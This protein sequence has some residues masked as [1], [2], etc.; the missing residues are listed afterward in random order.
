MTQEEEIAYL[1]AE[2]QD[3]R[4]QLQAALARIAELE[5]KAKEPPSFVKANAAKAKEKKVR[6]K[7]K[8]E[9]NGARRR[10]APTQIVEHR[11]EQCPE[12][13]LQL[14]GISLGRQRQ[15]IEVPPPPVLATW[16]IRSGKA[17]VK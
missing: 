1:R 5:R 8:P 6:K 4:A 14:G 7:R 3:L 10:E 17:A 11:I 16:Y 13:G 9:E 2:N 12:C 15:V